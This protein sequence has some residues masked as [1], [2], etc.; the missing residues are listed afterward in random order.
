MYNLKPAN[1]EIYVHV[2]FVDI[3]ALSDPKLGSTEEQTKKIETLFL[4][5]EQTNAYK[6]SQKRDLLISRTGD[7]AVI[8][9]K[10]NVRG[11]LELAIELHQKLRRYNS[12]KRPEKRVNVRIGINSGTVRLHKGLS[13]SPGFW[14]RG[15]INA[16]RIMDIAKPNNILLDSGI[17]KELDNLSSRYKKI[18]HYVGKATI[19]HEA[20]KLEIYSAHGKNFGSKIFPDLT[21]KQTIQ[22]LNNEYGGLTLDILDLLKWRMPTKFKIGKGSSETK[23]KSSKTGRVKGK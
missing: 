19:K 14:G 16:R 21:D 5:I 15:T 7:G 8:C 9:F 3:V 23:M 1:N 18:I 11:P 22:T 2:F 4:Y 20:E 13:V 12:N 6:N 10:K 17:A